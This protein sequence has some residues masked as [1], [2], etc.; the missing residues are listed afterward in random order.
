MSDPELPHCFICFHDMSS[1]FT[2]YFVFLRR[3]FIFLT[4]CYM[5]IYADIIH[6]INPHIL[7]VCHAASLCQYRH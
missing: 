6:L 7:Q 1:R 4:Q 5:V 3:F 2:L